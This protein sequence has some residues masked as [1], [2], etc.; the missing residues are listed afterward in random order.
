MSTKSTLVFGKGFS[1]YE[2]LLERVPH[3]WLALD[4]CEFEVSSRRVRVEI[5]LPVWEVLRQHTPA[6]FD[7]APL[8]DKQLL[9]EAEKRV[10]NVRAEYRANRA[11]ERAAR[12]AGNLKPDHKI[13]TRFFYRLASLPRAQH[14][15]AGRAAVRE[16]RTQQRRLLRA[17][18]RLSPPTAT[19]STLTTPP[20]SSPT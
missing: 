19:G 11:H 18:A 5:P 6:R 8:G 14:L 20:S 16:D 3:V 4:G 10:E 12:K 1:L 13:T 2:E 15:E 7:L 17:I 9:A